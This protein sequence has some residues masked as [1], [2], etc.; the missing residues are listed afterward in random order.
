MFMVVIS[1]DGNMRIEC[2]EADVRALAVTLH[3]ADGAKPDAKPLYLNGP[4][5]QLRDALD[6]ALKATP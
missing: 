1:T 3:T 5:K 2:S 4:S 6:R